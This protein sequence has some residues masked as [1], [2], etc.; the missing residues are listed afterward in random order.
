MWVRNILNILHTFFKGKNCSKHVIIMAAAV[1]HWATQPR[2][3]TWGGYSAVLT[4]QV[5]LCLICEEITS[6]FKDDNL[7]RHIVCR[8]M[9]PNSI[10]V[11]VHFIKI[12]QWNW[13]QSVISTKYLKKIIKTQMDSVIK[14]TYGVAKNLK[15]ISW[16][17]VY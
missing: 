14:V 4:N 8:N 9:Q 6:V 1:P 3:E 7:E 13:K 11:K 15:T 5:T 17:R 10:H 2:P 16:W 12:K